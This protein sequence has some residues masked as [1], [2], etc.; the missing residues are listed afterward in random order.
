LDFPAS[1]W[2][3]WHSQAPTNKKFLLLFSKRSLSLFFF[4]KKNQKT[5]TRFYFLSRWENAIAPAAAG[6]GASEQRGGP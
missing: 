1:R 4:E 3:V 6:R 5:F 2:P